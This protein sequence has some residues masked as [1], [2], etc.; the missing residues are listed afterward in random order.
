MPLSETLRACTS[1]SEEA[2]KGVVPGSGGVRPRPVPGSPFLELALRLGEDLPPVVSLGL[3]PELEDGKP[4]QILQGD[5]AGGDVRLLQDAKVRAEAGAEVQVGVRDPRPSL[6]MPMVGDDLP[7]VRRLQAVRVGQSLDL[8]WSAL[9]FGGAHAI[10]DPRDEI[11]F[12]PAAQPH[13]VA[14]VGDEGV[15]LPGTVTVGADQGPDVRLPVDAGDGQLEWSPEVVEGP[16]G[17]VACQTPRA[18]ELADG[19]EEHGELHHA[20]RVLRPVVGITKLA[21]VPLPKE[22][23]AAHVEVAPNLPVE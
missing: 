8:P 22:F 7:G 17:R 10:R 12:D 11:E 14:G 13:G 18:T 4:Q 6:G 23:L 1:V 2:G 9:A 20:G 5:P 3:D 15:F 19:G 21:G 16:V